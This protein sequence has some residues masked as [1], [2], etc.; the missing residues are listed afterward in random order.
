MVDVVTVDACR[1]ARVCKTSE[2]SHDHVLI[3]QSAA[4]VADDNTLAAGAVW[5]TDDLLWLR[6]RAVAIRATTS[7]ATAVKLDAVALAGDAEAVA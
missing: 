3:P 1:Y 6:V 4:R 7:G 5:L 2:I